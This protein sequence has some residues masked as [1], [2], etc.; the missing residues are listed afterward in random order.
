MDQLGFYL[1]RGLKCTQ[2]LISPF[3]VHQYVNSRNA[4]DLKLLIRE[5]NAMHP[6]SKDT[7]KYHCSA[8][9]WDLKNS[10]DCHLQ[11]LTKEEKI[12]PSH[13]QPVCKKW[14][15]L[16]HYHIRYSI[17]LSW[18]VYLV[19][20]KQMLFALF[21]MMKLSCNKSVN[22]TCFDTLPALIYTW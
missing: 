20:C 21:P 13:L 15:P 16:Y 2:H 10:Q 3:P 22:E 12:S 7:F 11:I 6:D 18:L 1:P 17:S 4:K 9:P 5:I 19:K 14:Y 8:G